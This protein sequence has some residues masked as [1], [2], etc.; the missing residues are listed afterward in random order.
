MVTSALPSITVKAFKRQTIVISWR[1]QCASGTIALI[2][3]VEV[4]RERKQQT[5]REGEIYEI[6]RMR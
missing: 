2:V 3:L 4:P 1:K 6:L 5:V